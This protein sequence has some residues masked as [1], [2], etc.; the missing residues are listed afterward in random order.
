MIRS[1]ISN[2]I[3][4][5]ISL[6]LILAIFIS[7]CLN[8]SY[9]EVGC[10]GCAALFWMIQ[11]RLSIIIKLDEKTQKKQC[12]SI[13]YFVLL[14]TI[15]VISN[16]ILLFFRDHLGAS[17]EKKLFIIGLSGILSVYLLLQM[18]GTLGNNFPAG[19]FT[20]Q[21]IIAALSAPMALII[22]LIMYI[23]GSDEASLLG[24]MSTVVFGAISL[25]IS[26]NMIL[27]ANSDYKST[28]DSIKRIHNIYKEHKLIITRLTIMKDA[29][30]VA[31]KMILSIISFSFFM[32]VNALYSIGMAVARGVTLKMHTQ[33]REKQIKSYRL[34]G[35]IVSIASICYVIY[36]VRLFFGGRTG[37]YG[38]NVSLLIALYTFT[39]LGI[40]IRETFRLRKSKVLQAKALRAIS[41]SATLLCFVLTQTAIMSFASEGNNNFTNALSG[42]V[43]GGLAA[44]GGLF[45]IR[46]SF[47][48]KRLLTE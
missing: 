38:M 34:V 8:H 32:F 20:R 28:R 21:L 48:H 6:P 24:G 10:A 44:L 35:I 33:D 22:V 37:N 1:L 12:S 16:G 47:H 17:L 45:V 11:L 4:P 9:F 31:G 30:L 39:E 36:S 2:K 13:G 19:R 7:G 23:T 3:F 26:L 15:G 41:F 40:N 27:V 29:A 18:I 25:L 43:F 5:F 42:V 46:D 14:P